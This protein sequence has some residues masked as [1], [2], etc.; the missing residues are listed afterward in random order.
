MLSKEKTGSVA[1]YELTANS[2]FIISFGEK[3][4]RNGPNTCIP[5]NEN[6][7]AYLDLEPTIQICIIDRSIINI[8]LTIVYNTSQK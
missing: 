3:S 4:K 5:F 2:E 8:P 7:I 1:N 6:Y